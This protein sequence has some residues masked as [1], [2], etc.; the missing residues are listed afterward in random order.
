MGRRS[1]I[2]ST[3]PSFSCVCVCIV[4]STV[5]AL[6][7]STQLEHANWTALTNAYYAS[8]NIHRNTKSLIVVSISYRYQSIPSWSLA[9]STSTAL[10]VRYYF[11]GEYCIGSIQPENWPECVF[12]LK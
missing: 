1:Q 11:A 3:W 10:K 5:D 2:N 7:R 12:L 6:K 9:N 8:D 4:A